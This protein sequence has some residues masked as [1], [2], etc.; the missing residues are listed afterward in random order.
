MVCI[1][2]LEAHLGITL[3]GMIG[4]SWLSQAAFV[5]ARVVGGDHV[6]DSFNVMAK[7]A[8]RD[9]SLSTFKV[10][11][12]CSYRIGQDGSQIVRRFSIQATYRLVWQLGSVLWYTSLETRTVPLKSI[13]LLSSGVMVLA[14]GEKCRACYDIRR[15]RGTPYKEVSVHMHSHLAQA[16]LYVYEFGSCINIYEH[17]RLKLL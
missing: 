1:W 3:R 4:C 14:K 17:R 5:G 7:R 13:C 6:W 2:Y 9:F 11:Q 8:T 12:Y 10:L 16:I 15:N